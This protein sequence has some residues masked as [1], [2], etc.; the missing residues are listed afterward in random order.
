MKGLVAE[1]NAYQELGWV[2][3]E[4]FVRPGTKEGTIRPLRLDREL[5]E[6]A[7]QLRAKARATTPRGFQKRV[8]R[9]ADEDLQ[10]YKVTLLNPFLEKTGLIAY[11]WSTA[12]QATAIPRDLQD[13]ARDVLVSRCPELPLTRR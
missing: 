12:A 5:D 4:Y 11:D 8:E 9:F 1:S 6:T 7:R 3:S 13:V 2:N 10:K